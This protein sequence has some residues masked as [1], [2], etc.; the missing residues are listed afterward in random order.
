MARSSLFVRYF[1]KLIRGV[2]KSVFERR[3]AIASV[4]I[5][6]IVQWGTGRFTV[7]SLAD[8]L[9]PEGVILWLFVVWHI[10]KAYFLLNCEIK[11]EI[12][13]YIPTIII[14]GCPRQNPPDVGSN[15]K[16]KLLLT[17]LLTLVIWCTASYLTQSVGEYI[18]SSEE[19]RACIRDG[20]SIKR[21]TEQVFDENGDPVP[22]MARGTFTITM[23]AANPSLKEIILDMCPRIMDFIADRQQ[24]APPYPALGWLA[25]RK[26]RAVKDYNAQTTKEFSNQYLKLL[27][28]WRNRMA[29][30]GL[31]DDKLD[32]ALESQ[33]DATSMR[34]I[35]GRTFSLSRDLPHSVPADP[36]NPWV[37]APQATR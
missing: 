17:A 5:A 15:Y 8:K 31:L 1:D 21:Y 35:V 12:K 22:G 13:A 19:N 23:F 24:H 20:E 34:I 3:L 28:A 11:E 27:K 9:I 30:V 2:C 4:T 14:P 26:M 37:P 6:L 10:L 18:S 16:P 36:D 33:T 25:P 32:K 7:N 29:A